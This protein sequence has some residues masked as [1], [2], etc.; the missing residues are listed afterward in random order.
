MSTT[1]RIDG[2]IQIT[3]RLITVLEREVEMLRKP[4]SD[5]LK[6]LQEE[7]SALTAAYESQARSLAGHPELLQALQPVLRAELER[8]TSRFQSAVS[9]NE[10]ALRAARETTQRVLQAIADELDKNRRDKA[11]YSPSGYGCT[12]SFGGGSQPISI[13]LDE[14]L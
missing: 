3:S 2:L 14:N 7:K 1:S 11:G 13:A 6:A 8:V 12:T 10:A 4:P 5:G 9:T